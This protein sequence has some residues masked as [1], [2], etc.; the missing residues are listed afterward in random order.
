MGKKTKRNTLTTVFKFR[1]FSFSM[2][3]MK[4]KLFFRHAD[5]PTNVGTSF[6]SFVVSLSVLTFKNRNDEIKYK[7]KTKKNYLQQLGVVYI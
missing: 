5:F 1:F 3:P 2:P 4:S 7:N 6:I